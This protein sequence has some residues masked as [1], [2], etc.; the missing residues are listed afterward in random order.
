MGRFI[1]NTI[2]LK[3]VG[4]RLLP[5]EKVNVAVELE[6]GLTEELEQR[7]ATL[8]LTNKRLIRYSAAGHRTN[9]ISAALEDVQTIEVNQAD[10]NRQWILAGLVFIAG[11]LLLGILSL[12]FIP[13]TFSPLLMALALVLIGIVFILTYVGG[14]RGEVIIRAG[15][16]EIKSKMAA[17]ALDDMAVLV[18]RFYEMKLGYTPED[19][20]TEEFPR[21]V[22]DDDDEAI[23]IVLAGDSADP[24]SD[25]PTPEP[26]DDYAEAIPHSDEEDDGA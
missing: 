15:T 21:P 1:L 7:R 9:V 11:G 12:V 2:T 10:Q 23:E 16:K 13:S 4:I 14:V 6:D 19:L 18:Q 8:L 25:S 3:Q 22:E 20:T 26:V 24:A 17:K 5:D